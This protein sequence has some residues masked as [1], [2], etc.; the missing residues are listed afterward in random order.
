MQNLKSLALAS[1]TV[2]LRAIFIS[3]LV[4]F[5]I[6]SAAIFFSAESTSFQ[7]YIPE[8]VKIIDIHSLPGVDRVIGPGAHSPPKAPSPAPPQA[9]ANS[10]SSSD[11]WYS[12]WSWLNPFSSS[13]SK[14]ENRVVLPILPTRCTVYTYYDPKIEFDNSVNDTVLLVWRRAWWAQGFTPVIL[15]PEEALRNDLSQKL[16]HQKHS[17]RLRYE[18]MRFL[19]WDYM[20]GGIFTDYRTIPIGPHDDPSLASLRRCEFPY[21]SRYQ[22]QQGYIYSSSEASLDALLQ[23]I[24][25][26]GDTVTSIEEATKGDPV[27]KKVDPLTTKDLWRVESEIR[28]LAIYTPTVID[29]L[30]HNLTAADFPNL[31]NAHL[32]N[33]FLEQFPGGIDILE[34]LPQHTSA[35]YHST[36]VLARKISTCP[37][38]PWP[39]S[40]PPNMKKCKPCTETT[41]PK[42]STI[43]SLK[44][45][46]KTSKGVAAAV[47]PGDRLTL[48]SVPHP[49]T[50]VAVIN[51]DQSIFKSK[52]APADNAIDDVFLQAYSKENTW[53]KAVT[54]ML[55]DSNL[56]ASNRSVSIKKAVADP[57]EI[58]RGLWTTTEIGWDVKEVEWQLGFSL[59]VGVSTAA[60]AAPKKEEL[61]VLER[62]HGFVNRNSGKGKAGRVMGVVEAWSVV[63]TEVWR[64]VR[65]VGERRGLERGKWVEKEKKWGK[66]LAGEGKSGWWKT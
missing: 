61:D 14:D 3:V 12:S 40:C 43:G 13:E 1:S 38:S 65:A 36:E 20:K 59:P 48:A 46:S 27:A 25:E 51:S 23:T 60:D 34:P 5:F 56:P 41:T 47:L 49:Y 7:P 58:Y 39:Y 24:T 44:Q 18:V 11:T 66:G 45:A 29:E 17:N 37:D 26:Q 54:S 19:A 30:Y 32:H 64:F 6:S 42:T 52:D 31:I 55:L 15:G 10:T 33:Y 9:V 16:L 62:A 2:N 53:V 35:L 28:S 22:N 57:S 50:L 63:D 21:L 8:N 4:F